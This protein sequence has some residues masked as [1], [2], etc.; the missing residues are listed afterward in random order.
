M[1]PQR[2]LPDGAQVGIHSHTE[3]ASLTS[4]PWAYNGKVSCLSEDGGQCGP[5][6]WACRGEDAGRT[7]CV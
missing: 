6:D 4:S 5:A 1:T 2:H 7:G 3:G